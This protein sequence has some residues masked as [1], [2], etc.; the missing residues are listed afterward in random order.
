MVSQNFA[1]LHP[2]LQILMIISM[3]HLVLRSYVCTT[4]DWES[5]PEPPGVVQELAPTSTSRN[6][7]F[8]HDTSTSLLNNGFPWN[9]TGTKHTRNRAL[10]SMAIPPLSDTSR[11]KYTYKAAKPRI[12]DGYNSNSYEPMTLT[13]DD[14]VSFEPSTFPHH[15]KQLRAGKVFHYNCNNRNG[16]NSSKNINNAIPSMEECNLT[17]EKHRFFPVASGVRGSATAAV[18]KG[19]AGACVMTFFLIARCKQQKSTQKCSHTIA[20]C[21]IQ[22]KPIPLHLKVEIKLSSST[23]EINFSHI[24]HEQ[25]VHAPLIISPPTKDPTVNSNLCCIALLEKHFLDKL[26]LHELFGAT[27]ITNS[28]SLPPPPPP[29]F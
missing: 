11:G 29:Q 9:G 16:N 19:G 24:G 10:S 1:Y 21:E 27:N 22:F 26:P 20:F 14:H 25:A 17:F 18:N 2:Y 13:L 7:S 28:R 3:P 5:S 4:H 15:W 23:D 6:P 8:A 12:D